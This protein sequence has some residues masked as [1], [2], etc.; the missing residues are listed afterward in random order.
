MIWFWM[1]LN[2]AKFYHFFV[3]GITLFCLFLSALSSHLHMCTLMRN[4]PDQTQQALLLPQPLWISWHSSSEGYEHITKGQQPPE[5]I[6]QWKFF[7]LMVIKH[8]NRLL[9]ITVG[10]FGFSVFICA[11]NSSS[12][13]LSNLLQL[14]PTWVGG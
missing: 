1:Y 2:T 12:K 4:A 8:W 14:D 13:S 3:T 10:G 11:Q 5:E 9:K 7:S 6:L